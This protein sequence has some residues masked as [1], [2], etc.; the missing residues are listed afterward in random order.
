[1]YGGDGRGCIKS[2]NVKVLSKH[3]HEMLSMCSIRWPTCYA[4]QP[5]VNAPLNAA[6]ICIY[7]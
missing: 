4:G 6:C 3:V 1:M 2:S 5:A 7:L